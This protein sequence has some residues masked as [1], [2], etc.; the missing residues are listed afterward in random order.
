MKINLDKEREDF[1]AWAFCNS[2]APYIIRS[3]LDTDKYA[4]PG[5]KY[6][7]AAWKARAALATQQKQPSYGSCKHCNDSGVVMDTEN[8]VWPCPDCSMPTESKE[9]TT[10]GVFVPIDILK[11]IAKLDVESEHD[12]NGPGCIYCSA[13]GAYTWM[14]WDKGSRK[15]NEELANL[16]HRPNCPSEFA[17]AALAEIQH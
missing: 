12:E 10:P 17:K 3:S 1:E 11:E 6:A 7:W 14:I 9:E 13:C 5:A 4:Y 16:K 2:D 8:I 15:E